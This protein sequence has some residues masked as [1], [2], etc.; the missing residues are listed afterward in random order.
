MARKAKHEPSGLDEFH[1][2]TTHNPEVPKDGTPVIGARPPAII[3]RTGKPLA[4]K[5]A[6]FRKD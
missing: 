2:D 5:R 1:P 3:G 4:D 6:R